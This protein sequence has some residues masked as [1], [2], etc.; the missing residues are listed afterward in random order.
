MRLDP[1]FYRCP[2]EL[3]FN[4]S[5]PGMIWRIIAYSI[6]EDYTLVT[7]RFGTKE[8]YFVGEALYQGKKLLQ[9]GG[10]QVTMVEKPE[11]DEN[12]A[13]ARLV[14]KSPWDRID[15]KLGANGL[16]SSVAHALRDPTKLRILPAWFGEVDEDVSP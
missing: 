3:G 5:G 16:S 9:A 8:N 10:G 7:W 12:N 4:L 6:C 14:D 2:P 13:L 15:P 1:Y 11:F